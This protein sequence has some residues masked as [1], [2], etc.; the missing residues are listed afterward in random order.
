M[1]K[2]EEIKA[3]IRIQFKQA[4]NEAWANGA[5]RVIVLPSAEKREKN[6]CD[7]ID[8]LINETDTPKKKN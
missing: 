6:I 2:K 3:A 8:E 1:N 7:L 5:D 4:V